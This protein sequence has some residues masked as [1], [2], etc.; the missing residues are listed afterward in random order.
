MMRWT[1]AALVLGL[2]AC[3]PAAETPVSNANSAA[4]ACAAQGGRIERVGRAQTE[5]CVIPFADG[6]RACTDG[7]QCSSGNCIGSVEAAQS[8]ANASGQCQATNMRFGCYS[9]IVNGRAQQAICVD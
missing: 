7:S 4:S 1:A 8:Q 6:G 5:Q 2:C 3:A 9:T